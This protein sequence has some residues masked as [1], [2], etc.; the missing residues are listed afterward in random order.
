[1]SL[2]ELIPKMSKLSEMNVICIVK[3]KGKGKYKFLYG[4]EAEKMQ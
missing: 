3:G 4:D 1:M 2:K